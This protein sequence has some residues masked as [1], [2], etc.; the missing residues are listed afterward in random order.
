VA[1]GSRRILTGTVL[2][3]HVRVGLHACMEVGGGL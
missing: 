1:E 2:G 3:V